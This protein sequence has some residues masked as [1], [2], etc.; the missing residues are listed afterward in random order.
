MLDGRGHSD[1]LH[2][3]IYYDGSYPDGLTKEKRAVRRRA[4]TLE[5]KKDEVFLL[6]KAEKKQSVSV[7]EGN[8]GRG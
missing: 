4:A 6:R 2:F 8:P 5:T 7:T 3:T 1:I